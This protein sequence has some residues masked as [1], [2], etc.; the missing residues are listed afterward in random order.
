MSTTQ[1]THPTTI[2]TASTAASSG[3]RTCFVCEERI[4]DRTLLI[5]FSTHDTQRAV[6]Q[7]AVHL[8]CAGRL[9]DTI[10]ASLALQ[11]R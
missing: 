7:I 2:I 5:D 1:S 8:S 4:T 3:T 10:R 9:A 11:C 6:N